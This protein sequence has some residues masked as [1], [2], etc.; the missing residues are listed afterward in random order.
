MLSIAARQV[1]L[2]KYNNLTQTGFKV[3]ALNKFIY[4]CDV[5]GTEAFSVEKY[6]KRYLIF[7]IFIIYLQSEK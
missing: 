1:S 4:L 6:L 7:K 3:W 5:K 2:L